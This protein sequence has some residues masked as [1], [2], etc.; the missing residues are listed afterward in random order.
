MRK[1]LTGGRPNG[2]K[3]D[4]Q[5][6]DADVR[7][8]YKRVTSTML[9][10]N[11]PFTTTGN[12]DGIFIFNTANSGTSKFDVYQAP[13]NT[14]TN[15]VVTSSDKITSQVANQS[16]AVNVTVP[17]P[18]AGV[19]QDVVGARARIGLMFYNRDEGG[20]VI[21]NVA[22]G[23]LPSVINQINLSTPNTN[24]PLAEALWSAV[25]YFAQQGTISGYNSPSGTA[26]L[27]HNA[28]Y[29]TS[30]NSDPM[31]FG[32][33]GTPR[34]PVCQK[35][36]VLLLTDG[37]PCSDGHIPTNIRDYPIGRSPFQCVDNSVSPATYQSCPSLSGTGY[38]FPAFEPREQSLRRGRGEKHRMG[39][40]P[41][42][43][44]WRCSCTP[45]TS[46]APRRSA[47]TTSRG[48]RT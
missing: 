13:N 25:G 29:G 12:K 15:N 11:T 24:T 37:E 47:R 39:P 7:G 30:N 17:L 35:N 38:S 40:N 2:T 20:Q 6:A 8:L 33:G 23:S 4:G 45:T 36:F 14:V 32:T 18:V 1:V 21:T 31:N 43:R 19:L 5:P 44:T 28:D 3:V 42:S 41:A 48:S 10:A 46:E 16:I 9:T 34:W 26:P 22:G 27:Y